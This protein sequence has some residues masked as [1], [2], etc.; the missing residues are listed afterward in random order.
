MIEHVLRDDALLK[1]VSKLKFGENLKSYTTQRVA[2][3]ASARTP[4]VS[5]AS[6][7]R[8]LT[9]KVD[10]FMSLARG[11]L[12]P[13]CIKMVSHFHHVHKFGTR[14]KNAQL[15]NVM[16]SSA[17]LAWLRRKT[18]KCKWTAGR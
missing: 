15:E 5:A 3:N 11:L 6:C 16:P 10:R 7:N 18:S 14:R 1:T 17:T 12:V 2:N 8:D 9:V 13:S 4:N